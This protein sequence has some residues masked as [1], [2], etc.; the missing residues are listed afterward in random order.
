MSD[1]A[2][3][4]VQ[5]ERTLDAPVGRVWAMWAEAE[6]FAQWYGPQGATIPVAEFDHRVGGRRFVVMEMDTPNGPMQMAL[7]GEYLEIDEPSRLVYTEAPAD[8]EGNPIPPEQAGMPPG[9]PGTTRVVVSLE[10]V[11]AQT[12]LQLS[13]IHISEPT[14]Q[15]CLSRM[16]SSA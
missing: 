14:R 13:L 9:H 16:P 7:V 8:A 11:G 3:D 2:T 1:D 4:S 15:I 6:H 12:R 5:I 10:P